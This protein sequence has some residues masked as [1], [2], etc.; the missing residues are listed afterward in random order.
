MSAFSADESRK[1]KVFLLPFIS[2]VE[3]KLAIGGTRTESRRKSI[4]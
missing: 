4:T 2:D 3:T 1:A